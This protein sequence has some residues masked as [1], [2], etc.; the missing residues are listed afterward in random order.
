VPV[1]AGVGAAVGAAVGAEEVAATVK[2]KVPDEPDASVAPVKTDV[3]PH[4]NAIEP[5][6]HP[7][8]YESFMLST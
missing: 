4:V 8:P 7:S 5:L 3:V 2:S 1:V 6:F